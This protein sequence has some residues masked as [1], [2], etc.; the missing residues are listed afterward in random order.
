MRRLKLVLEYDG[1]AYHGWQ[2]QKNASAVQDIL[3]AKLKVLL[4]KRA[5]RSFDA[6][7]KALGAIA[8]LFSID[9]CQN[10]FCSAGYEAE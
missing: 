4:R 3:E 1:G 10:F 5:A 9:E 7:A 2:S 6:I 8:N